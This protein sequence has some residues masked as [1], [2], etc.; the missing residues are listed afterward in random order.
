MFDAKVLKYKPWSISKANMFGLCSRQ[1]GF[2]YID[3]LKEGR[4]SASSRVGT[5]AHAVQ[6][7]ARR[8]SLTGDAL[9]EEAHRIIE[10]DGLT[11]AEAVEVAAK[12][13]AIADYVT[14][15]AA[16][17]ATNGV[18]RELIEHQLAIDAQWQ[19]VPF[20]DN[21]NGLFRGVIDDALWTDDDVL[22]V[23]D[24]KSGRKKPITEHSTQFYA[25]MGLVVSNFP[26]IRGVQC[27]INYFGEPRLDW[28]PRFDG[29]S[30]PW[31]REEIHLHVVPWV[32]SYLN[33]LTKRLTVLD[34]GARDPE[35]GWQC[36]YCGYVDQCAEGAEHAAKRRSK[37]GGG[38]TNL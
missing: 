28:F 8:G 36:E 23:I 34:S 12:V 11:H 3:K 9:M 26:E 17:K 1:A 37:R 14:R 13:P 7:S 31:T 20:F 32:E 5:A 25:Y 22:I 4:K 2:K 6:E 16:F 15:V 21:E 29:S 30:G 18:K 35:T 10:K 33:R 19:P 24:H 27:A 38:T